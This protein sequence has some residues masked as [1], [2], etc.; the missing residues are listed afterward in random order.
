MSRMVWVGMGQAPGQLG[1]AVSLTQP[2]C[3]PS[4]CGAQEETR[5]SDQVRTPALGCWQCWT[6]DVDHCARRQSGLWSVKQR[7]LELRPRRTGL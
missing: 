1:R 7:G 2:L 5:C 6:P 3:L 4:V